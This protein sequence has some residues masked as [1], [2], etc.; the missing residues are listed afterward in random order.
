[1][2]RRVPPVSIARRL[3]GCVLI[4]TA[5]ACRSTSSGSSPVP[6]IDEVHIVVDLQAGQRWT[7]TGPLVDAGAFCPA[8]TRIEAG[9]FDPVT[10]ELL[11]PT[12]L[13]SRAEEEPE[14]RWEPFDLVMHHE[15]ACLDGSGSFLVEELL[16]DRD[17]IGV[18]TILSGTGAYRAMSGTGTET[19]TA[20]PTAE[21]DAAALD[22]RLDVTIGVD[23]DPG[24]T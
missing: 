23:A 17:P 4:A 8:G 10:G 13:E 12:E 21:A 9:A 5:P 24:R 1:M 19:F 22:I 14:L 2:S 6:L 7:A 16:A 20:E 3:L 11:T 18:L 15:Y